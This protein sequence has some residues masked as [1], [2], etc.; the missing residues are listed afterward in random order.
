MSEMTYR[1]FDDSTR[2]TAC[3]AAQGGQDSSSVVRST[4]GDGIPAQETAAGGV[5]RDAMVA[6]D[7]LDRGE[8]PRTAH[9]GWESNVA[10]HLPD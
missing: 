8:M 3:V 2:Q 5:A 10:Y 7:A 1:V 4:A 6:S 9:P